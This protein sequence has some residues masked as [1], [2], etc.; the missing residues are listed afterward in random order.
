MKMKLRWAGAR[1]ALFSVAMRPKIRVRAAHGRAREAKTHYI[2]YLSRVLCLCVCVCV[3]I[4]V[5]TISYS[6]SFINQTDQGGETEG[7]KREGL[8]MER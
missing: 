2:I 3:T 6:F 7:L 4:C 5:G 8:K 1:S